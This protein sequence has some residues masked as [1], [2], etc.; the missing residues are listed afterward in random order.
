MKN[1][2]LMNKIEE[3]ALLREVVDDVKN[4]QLVQFWNK[5]GI[6][7]I[8]G[9]ALVLTLTISFEGIKNWQIKKHQETSNAYSAALSLQNQGRLDESLDIY[10]TLA[11]KSTGIYSDIARLQIASIYLEQDKK[12]DAMNV[13]EQL[14]KDGSVDQIR[15]VAA[16]KLASYKLDSKA[17]A[18][19]IVN[20]LRPVIERADSSDVAHEL[21]AMLY[22]REHDIAKAYGEYEKIKYSSHASDSM[23]S[24]ALDMMNIL[25]E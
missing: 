8:I 22:V 20:L 1:K 13:L 17:S 16:L 7:V 10:N 12:D 11:V 25:E 23:K 2:K 21:M 5:Y 4:D 14:S 6:F 9:V 19:E 15:D 3:D 24:R 18:E